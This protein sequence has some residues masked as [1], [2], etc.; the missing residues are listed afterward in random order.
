M[1]DVRNIH[2]GWMNSDWNL[3]VI[4]TTGFQQSHV[5]FVSACGKILE[6]WGAVQWAGW[7]TVHPKFWFRGPQC[8]GPVNNWPSIDISSLSINTIINTASVGEWAWSKWRCTVAGAARRA[9]ST[10]W[11]CTENYCGLNWG[12]R[13]GAFYSIVNNYGKYNFS[14]FLIYNMAADLTFLACINHHY[15]CHRRSV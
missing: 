7:A 12:L 8:I 14:G 10:G 15:Q 3:S 1:Y 9:W 2:N 6:Q 5:V 13:M 4:K 11:H